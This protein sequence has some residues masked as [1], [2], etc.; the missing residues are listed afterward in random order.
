[1]HVIAHVLSEAHSVGNCP[2][3]E[4][5]D[6][7]FRSRVRLYGI[8]VLGVA[9]EATKVSPDL[10]RLHIAVYNAK[11][12]IDDVYQLVRAEL[13]KGF[14]LRIPPALLRECLNF[15]ERGRSDFHHHGMA[16][17]LRGI[18]A[19]WFRCH[20]GLFLCVRQAYPGQASMRQ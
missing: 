3:P 11:G 1:M 20:L 7:V 6:G 10:C 14:A 4:K 17:C 12:V 2:V 18:A 8:P 19:C 15:R 5:G 13:I 9:H 16:R